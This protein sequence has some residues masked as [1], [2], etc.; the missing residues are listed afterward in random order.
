[1]YD[2][3]ILWGAAWAMWTL[4]WCITYL[5][6]GTRRALVLASVGATLAISSRT[7]SGVVGVV[8]LGTVFG[9]QLIGSARHGGLR[10]LAHRVARVAGFDDDL[11]GRRPWPAAIATA[12]P[13]VAYGA[14]NWAK[15][16]NPFIVPF[17][18]QDIVNRA[19]PLRRAVL[20][21]NGHDLLALNEIPTNLFNYFRPDG[22]S[23][24]RLFP[25]VDFTHGVV[26]IGSPAR[27]IEWLSASLTVT[28][29]LL[30]ALAVVGLAAVCIPRFATSSD[31][32]RVRVL[33]V[34]ALAAL[35]SLGPT[36]MFPSV[37][38]RYTVD[39]T[40]ALVLLGATGM[41]VASARLRH[42]R[43]ARTIVVVVASVILAWNVAANAALTL[44]LQRGYQDVVTPAHRAA[45]VRDRIRWTERLGIGPSATIV[46]WDP[47]AE[48]K[49]AA[50][51][52]GSFLVVGDCKAMLLSDGSRWLP[53]TVD[54]P[55]PLC[56]ALGP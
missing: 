21:A 18:H 17:Q 47:A 30:L 43:T 32:A 11:V 35:I 52:L 14:V 24:E 33:R 27:D 29:T 25:F 9:V 3:A 31:L 55:S 51:P 46:R 1:V 41:Y 6:R 10:T 15:F 50:G 53:L 48:K 42:H 4:S 13:I 39:F 37:F 16:G 8:V 2:E 22:I 28:A 45:W 56:R 7:S 36:L 44:N 26:K 19:D 20:A 54:D 5:V 23:F 12:V 34:P 40:P 49:P 38:E